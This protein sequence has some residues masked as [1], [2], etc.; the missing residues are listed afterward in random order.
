MSLLQDVLKSNSGFDSLESRLGLSEPLANRQF[1][2]HSEHV[3]SDDDWINVTSTSGSP[4]PTRPSSPSRGSF[5]SRYVRGLQQVASRRDP[6]R[7]LPTEICQR[8]FAHLSLSDLANCA[9]VCK[10]WAR[11]QTINYVWFQHYRKENFIDTS[12]PPG[13]WTKRESRQNWRVLHLKCLSEKTPPTFS[14]ASGS[15]SASRSGYQTPRELKEEQWR[16]E[17]EG[18][19]RPGK[20]EMREMYKEL[21]GRKARNK[22]KLGS[23][24]MR[25]KGGWA[26]THSDL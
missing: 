26:E 17:A 20:Q 19:F 25:D 16:I 21:G 13:K 12:L 6:L 3:D 1:T 4:Y 9:L 15:A 8:V 7:L 11:S 14:R 5:S 18:S 10:K 22:M 2:P 24:G 23:A